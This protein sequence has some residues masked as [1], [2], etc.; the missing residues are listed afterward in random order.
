MKKQLRSVVYMFLISL[1]F[2]SLVSAV[3]YLNEKKIASNQALKLQRIILKVLD[4]QKETPKIKQV[5]DELGELEKK[6]KKK[7]PAKKKTVKKE[8]L[9]K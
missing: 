9:S 3:M 6:G 4:K 1:F 5:K 2:A 8:N 7:K